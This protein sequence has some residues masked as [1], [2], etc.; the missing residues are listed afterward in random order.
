MPPRF[1]YLLGQK[2]STA[3][4]MAASIIYFTLHYLY[5]LSSN[6]YNYPI[7]YHTLL[8]ISDFSTSFITEIELPEYTWLELFVSNF[9]H[10]TSLYQMKEL[11]HL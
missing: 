5:L 7:I 4:R 8:F 9:K 3:E 11:D 10:I 6:Y 2:N 1:C